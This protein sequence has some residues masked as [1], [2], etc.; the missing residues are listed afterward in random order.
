MCCVQD[1]RIERTSVTY[2]LVWLHRLLTALMAFLSSDDKDETF[3]KGS[4]HSGIWSDAR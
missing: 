3:W 4:I 1:V 2:A